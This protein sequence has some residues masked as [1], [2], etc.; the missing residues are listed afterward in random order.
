MNYQEANSQLT[1]RYKNSRKLANNTYLKRRGDNI[2]VMLH[3]TDIV[4][5]KP[6]GKTI[7]NSGGWKTGTT[8][9]RLNQFGPIMIFQD[10][11]IWYAGHWNDTDCPIFEDGIVIKADGSVQSPIFKDNRTDRLLKQIAAYCKK[12]KGL[13]SLPIPSSGDCWSCALF[14]QKTTTGKKSTS[15][16]HLL[17]HLKEKYIHGSLIFNA[18]KWAGYENPEFIFQMDFRTTIVSAVRRYFKANLGLAI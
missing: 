9:D 17:S 14:D 2:A 5:F 13:E 1:G 3:E 18:M 7:L 8:K 6:N 4:N 16:D 11:G 10:K 12:L 15:Q